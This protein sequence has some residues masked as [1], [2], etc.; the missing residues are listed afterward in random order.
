MVESHSGNTHLIKKSKTLSVGRKR[1]ICR[2]VH[3]DTIPGSFSSFAILRSSSI[4]QSFGSVFQNTTDRTQVDTLGELNLIGGRG[5]WPRSLVH[6][7][8]TQAQA[9][10]STKSNNEIAW[11]T[12]LFRTICVRHYIE[13]TMFVQKAHRR[14]V[15]SR[16]TDVVRNSS[17]VQQ[18]LS[19]KGRVFQI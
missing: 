17:Y 13:R 19:N 16:R 8:E 4:L 5:L 11:R 3:H 15:V 12:M 18:L 6:I 2:T 1:Y 9:D 10:A 7:A 14:P